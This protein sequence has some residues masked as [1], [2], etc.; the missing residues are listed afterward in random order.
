M[1]LTT[2]PVNE[3]GIKHKKHRKN[4][5]TWAKTLLNKCVAYGQSLAIVLLPLA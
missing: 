2:N 3:V 4:L 5:F 1:H